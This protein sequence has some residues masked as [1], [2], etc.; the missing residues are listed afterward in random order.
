MTPTSPTPDARAFK[1]QAESLRQY[2]VDLTLRISRERTV[3][4]S[5][6]D[7][8]NGGPDGMENPGQET[9]VCRILG[10]ELDRIAVPY[11][12]HAQ[13]PGRDSLLATV[14]RREPGYRQLLVLLHTD[15]VPSG[16]PSDWRFPPFEPFEKD[17]T[18][19]G[20]GVL[21]DKGPLAASFAALRILKQHERHI[22][23]AFT[24][25]AVADEEVG[26][27]VGLPFL[28]E[29]GL[30]HCT[31]AVI[32]DIAGNM[33]EINVA[34]KGRVLLK[35]RARGKQAHAMDPSKGVNAIHALARFLTA[36]E[37]FTPT[38]TTHAVLG[39]P[40]VNTG[41]VRGGVAPNAVPADAE[42]TLDIRY[43]PGQTAEAI[44]AEVQALADRALGGPE[45]MP[46]ASIRIE[47]AQDSLP[48]EVS[49]DAP[50]VRRLLRHAPDAKVIGSGGGTFAKDLVLAGVDAVGWA[51]GDEETY[52]QPNE[53]I[54]VRQ[55]VVFAGR[56]AALAFE[57][58]SEKVAAR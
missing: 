20:R 29:S 33:K 32:P 51:P 28:I 7:F 58:A 43:V 31:D 6:E 56:L 11:T 46:G 54:D 41:L 45:G 48:C 13:V 36:L 1:E 8:P 18:L 9:R 39:G 44:R 5:P 26:S 53:E 50:I 12:T 34:E 16:A 23:G 27:G 52:H 35:A 14:G 24:F 22:P 30:I 3:N 47:I 4:Y 10:A 25:G 17:G 55:L 2:I 38:H 15:T 19:Y 40:T 42:A 49:P 57:I 21:D 37:R